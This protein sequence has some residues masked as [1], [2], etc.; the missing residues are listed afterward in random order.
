M[1][2]INPTMTAYLVWIQQKNTTFGFS[3]TKENTAK[4]FTLIDMNIA[5]ALT[6]CQPTATSV[7]N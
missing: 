5:L 2:K 4:R 7:K 1:G 6:L 3:S